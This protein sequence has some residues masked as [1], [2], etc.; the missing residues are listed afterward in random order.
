MA[1][2]SRS[3]SLL[4]LEE[5]RDD[6]LAALQ[7]HA[8]AMMRQDIVE[9][10]NGILKVGYNDHSDCGGGCTKHPTLR[11]ASVVVQVWE[12]WFLQFDLPL[13]TWGLPNFLSMNERAVAAMIAESNAELLHKMVCFCW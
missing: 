10:V 4:F 1:P 6:V 9:S 12:W 8:M 5:D 7:P 13:H 3:H 2:I 11:E